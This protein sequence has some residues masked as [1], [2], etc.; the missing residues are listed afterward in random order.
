MICLGP[1]FSFVMISQINARLSFNRCLVW[2]NFS[3]KLNLSSGWFHVQRTAGNITHTAHIICAK[4]HRDSSLFPFA[5][6]NFFRYNSNISSKLSTIV[7]EYFIKECFIEWICE[8]DT[9]PKTVRARFVNT[10][11]LIT[12]LLW[13]REAKAFLHWF[14]SLHSSFLHQFS[15]LSCLS[16]DCQ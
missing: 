12:C 9:L 4:H 5:Q 7:A 13:F 10:I 14:Q 6:K 11:F 3:N 15:H 1:P 2:F 8:G 16:R